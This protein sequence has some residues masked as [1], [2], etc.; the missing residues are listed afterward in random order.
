MR[1]IV[2]FLIALLILC[3]SAFADYYS[4]DYGGIITVVTVPKAVTESQDTNLKSAEGS[5]FSFFQPLSILPG[6]GLLNLWVF[7][8]GDASIENIAKKADI[9]TIHHVDEKTS[10]FTLLWQWFKM[11]SYKVYGT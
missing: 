4:P 1:K 6:L 3:P 11:K 5:Y 2:L 8:I 9:K 7:S 10:S